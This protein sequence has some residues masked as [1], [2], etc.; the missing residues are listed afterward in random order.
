MMERI[1]NISLNDSIWPEIA[2]LFPEM[3]PKAQLQPKLLWG[4]IMIQRFS[5][6][7]S[8]NSHELS[9]ASWRSMKAGAHTGDIEKFIIRFIMTTFPRARQKGLDSAT[10]LL[11]NGVVDSVGVLELVG[12]LETEFGITITD[13]DLIPGNFQTV[14]QIGAF[15]QAKQGTGDAV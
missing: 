6:N 13:E 5:S 7:V 9:D 4:R 2:G 1:P 11:E 12:F 8:P 14:A 3:L 15:V 10:L